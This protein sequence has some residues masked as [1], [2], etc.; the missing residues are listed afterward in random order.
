MFSA[1]WFVPSWVIFEFVA[2]KLP[3]Y[4]MPLLPALALPVAAA[5]IE[6]AGTASRKIHHAGS[7]PSCWR[8]RRSGLRRCRFCRSDRSGHL[9]VTARSAVIVALGAVFGLAAAGRLAARSR[10]Y[11]PCRRSA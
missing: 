4:T 11:M 3:H 7:R 9:A 5:M 1:C 6:G 10:A 2:T 8:C